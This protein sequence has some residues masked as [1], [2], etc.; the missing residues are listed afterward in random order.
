MLIR[1]LCESE[2]SHINPNFVIGAWRTRNDLHDGG[3][4]HHVRML[5]YNI[6]FS[7]DKD[8]YDRIVEWMERHDG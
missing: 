2:E 1:R 7:I 4:E 8:S 5:G 3:Y 6:H